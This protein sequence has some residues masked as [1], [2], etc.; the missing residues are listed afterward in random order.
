[1]NLVWHNSWSNRDFSTFKNGL[2]HFGETFR[3]HFDFKELVK[4]IFV[5][6]LDNKLYEL[7]FDLWSKLSHLVQSVVIW[8]GDILTGESNKGFV[9]KKEFGSVICS[10]MKWSVNPY[11]CNQFP[12]IEW[13]SYISGIIKK[14]IQDPTKY[15]ASINHPIRIVHMLECFLGTSIC[16]NGCGEK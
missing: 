7:I 4:L 10:L 16:R 14:V 3:I 8:R 13:I 5:I 11:I 9:L 1:M 15:I 2:L 6:E 12:C